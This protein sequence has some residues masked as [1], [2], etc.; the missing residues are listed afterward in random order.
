MKE[1]IA[2]IKESAIQEIENAKTLQELNDVRVKYSGKKG[3]LTAVL[4]GMKDLSAEERPVIGN[5]VNQ[6]KQE[7]EAKIKAGIPYV[8]RQKMPKYG[9]TEVN[10][11]LYGKIKIDNSLLEDQILLKSDGYPTY[12]FANVIDDHLMNITH[13]I[14]GSEYLSSTPKYNLL[15]KSFG[16]DIP[17]YIHLPLINAGTPTFVF[18][19]WSYEKKSQTDKRAKILIQAIDKV[20]D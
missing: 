10:D 3:E 11:L 8:I 18:E 15:Y 4:K 13:V 1:Q 16:W 14:R 17:T 9:V 5:L 2:K 20:F 12:N 6:T 19:T 7:I